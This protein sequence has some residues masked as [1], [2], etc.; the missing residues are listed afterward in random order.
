MCWGKNSNGQLGV[1]D[2]TDRMSPV[3]VPGAREC[4][5]TYVYIHT[6]I[7]IYIHTHTYWE[8]TENESRVHT[9]TRT[10]THT[11]LHTHTIILLRKSAIG[12]DSRVYPYIY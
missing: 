11:H 9:H 10:Q 7:Q 5:H 4:I 3:L 1:G 12:R 6:Y 8:A 2:T